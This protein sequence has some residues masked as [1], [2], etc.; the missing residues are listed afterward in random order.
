[1]LESS[2][3]LQSIEE[4]PVM[5]SDGQPNCDQLISGTLDS[6]DVPSLDQTFTSSFSGYGEFQPDLIDLMDY[7]PNVT[8]SSMVTPSLD[9][10][11]SSEVMDYTPTTV[12]IKTT[13]NTFY[14]QPPGSISV[15]PQTFFM[16][17]PSNDSSN[18]VSR[19]A[20]TKSQNLQ[21]SSKLLSLLKA[22]DTTRCRHPKFQ[23]QTFLKPIAKAKSTVS[24]LNDVFLSQDKNKPKRE[25]FDG[26]VSWAQDTKQQPSSPTSSNEEMN[27]P[28]D[29]LDLAVEYCANLAPDQAEALLSDL[30]DTTSLEDNLY[31]LIT[32]C[33][34]Q[35][36]SLN[37]GG[38][39][40]IS[41]LDSSQ[42]SNNH[43]FSNASQPVSELA[44]P[45]KNLIGSTLGSSGHSV[46]SVLSPPDGSVYKSSS[47]KDT[48]KMS[49][50]R[51]AVT[52]PD[53]DKTY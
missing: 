23:L 13:T 28:D 9:V 29:L 17:S 25:R 42:Q 38:S 32:S 5:T 31:S 16:K 40:Q 4:S 44:Q 33:P 12:Y 15:L 20:P 1:M 36:K 24:I 3:T 10:T 39:K 2:Q 34:S 22:S 53:V 47:G 8:E 45:S 27:L 35:S 49:L 21:S 43:L 26:T 14:R 48:N 41:L 50:L 30:N 46:I 37:T 6:L 18:F 11:P 51:A 52:S 7:T 19:H